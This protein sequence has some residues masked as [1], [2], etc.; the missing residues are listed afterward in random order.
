PHGLLVGTGGSGKTEALRTIVLSVML[1]HSPEEL[2]LVLVGTPPYMFF[3]DIMIGG[4]HVSL[5]SRFAFTA[6][7]GTTLEEVCET[8]E[9]EL[10]RR[11][12]VL[13]HQR[14]LD[15]SGSTMDRQQAIVDSAPFPT[16][17]LII[18]RFVD[19]IAHHPR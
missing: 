8:I 12:H 18:D 1:T 16:L 11:R 15:R 7:E 10:A 19:A 14:D 9:R 3:D 2:N 13:H 17:L 5:A 4:P 6:G